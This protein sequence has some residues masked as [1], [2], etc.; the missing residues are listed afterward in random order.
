MEKLERGASDAVTDKNGNL[1]LVWWKDIKQALVGK[2]PLRKAH[3]YVKAQNGRAEIEQTQSIFLY[4]KRYGKSWSPQSKH[5]LLHNSS[6]LQ[7]MVVASFPFL[8]GSITKQC[9][10]AVPSTEENAL[11]ENASL[12]YWDFGKVL[13]IHIIDVFENQQQEISSPLH[14]S[15]RKSAM[16]FDMMQS[17]TG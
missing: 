6:S 16:K 5:Q 15:Y 2:M 1:M 8:F 3:C 9:R 17:F 11:R 4:N 12:I 10:S 7:K 13:L 14:E